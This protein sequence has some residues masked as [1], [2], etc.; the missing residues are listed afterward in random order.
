MIVIDT[1]ALIAI[2]FGEPAARALSTRIAAEPAGERVMSVASYLEAGTV[3]AGRRASRP[4]GAVADLEAIL[5]EA[6]IHLKPIDEAQARIALDARIRLGR[7]FGAP[8]GLN[9]GDCFS[10][11]LAKSLGAPLLFVGDDFTATDVE[12]ALPQP[13]P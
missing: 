13:A 7:G 1:S 12:A 8:A 9:F 11:A 3:M 5:S 2:L 4:L 10:Y 6:S